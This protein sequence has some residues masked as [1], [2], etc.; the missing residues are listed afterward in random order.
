MYDSSDDEI[1]YEDEEFDVLGAQLTVTTVAQ[2]PLHLLAQLSSDNQE[3]SGQRVWGGSLL[4]AHFLGHQYSEELVAAAGDAASVLELGTGSGIAG[5]ALA[6]R[7]AGALRFVLTDGDPKA[8]ELLS[9]NVRKNRVDA[10]VR[11]LFWGDPSSL[12]GFRA[13]H[14]ARFPVAIA[15]DVLYKE[16][17]IAPLL[18]TVKGVLAA[19]GTF[20]LCHI[21]RYTVTHGVVA[22]GLAAHGFAVAACVE[23]AAVLAATAAPETW[24]EETLSDIA[25]AKL[26]ICKVAAP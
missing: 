24:D 12:E 14:E 11:P 25:R 18:E 19:S 17:L 2:L 22:D 3:I 8:V 20:C 7:F 4:L 15:G 13:A 16:E 23:P 26:Y 10:D 1:E 9:E 6:R 5:M 21:P